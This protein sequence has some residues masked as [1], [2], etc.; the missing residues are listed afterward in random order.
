MR[1]YHTY[2]EVIA[3]WK[4]QTPRNDKEEKGDRQIKKKPIRRHC[5]TL[6]N[7]QILQSFA[8]TVTFK[9]LLSSLFLKYCNKFSST[10][11]IE[12]LYCTVRVWFCDMPNV[13][14]LAVWF[15]LIRASSQYLSISVQR[16]KVEKERLSQRDAV[17]WVV[18]IIT[19]VKL[20]LERECKGG[21]DFA[22]N[23]WET[24]DEHVGV[25]SFRA[26]PPIVSGDV[27]GKSGC[28]R[29]GQTDWFAWRRWCWPR[30]CRCCP[31]VREHG[32]YCT[33]TG[34]RP[35]RENVNS[36]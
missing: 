8:H 28:S 21:W 18:Q 5:Q 20:H 22:K 15:Y 12:R 27:R 2:R 24:T 25:K 33:D 26:D 30:W 1:A 14:R 11:L 35:L 4:W 17:D 32:D 9:V 23:C 29:W 13:W 31:P 16:R 3:E 7:T 19:L 6:T 34:L 10:D 36:R